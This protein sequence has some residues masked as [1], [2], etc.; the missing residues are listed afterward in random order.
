MKIPEAE[1]E[2]EC[3]CAYHNKTSSL[4]A[5]DSRLITDG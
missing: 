5:N 3:E 1:E 2:A 4:M